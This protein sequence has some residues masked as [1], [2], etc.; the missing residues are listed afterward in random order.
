MNRIKFCLRKITAFICLIM[1]AVILPLAVSANS[2][3]PV[4]IIHGRDAVLTFNYPSRATSNKSVYM[5]YDSENG[6]MSIYPRSDFT[7]TDTDA[8]M[9]D[10]HLGYNTPVDGAEYIAVGVSYTAGKT[11]SASVST[12]DAVIS[13]VD[14]A[15]TSEIQNIVF[16]AS[17]AADGSVYDRI[18]FK[19]GYAADEIITTDVTFAVKYIA[20][21]ET[22][23]AAEAYVYTKPTEEAPV[24]V[25]GNHIKSVSF[26]VLTAGH[27]LSAAERSYYMAPTI[28]QYDPDIIGLQEANSTWY[29][30]MS[31][32][33]GDNYGSIVK[34]RTSSDSES[35]PIFWKKDKFELLDS[36][37]FWLSE[38]PDTESTGWGA[39]YHRIVC[40]V[41]LKVRTTGYE[42]YYFNTHWD[43]TETPQIESA[44]LFYNKITNECEGLPVILSA[45]FNMC[46]N[47]EGYAMLDSFL[48]ES[49]RDRDL[50]NTYNAKSDNVNAGSL[51][52]FVFYTGDSIAS[53]NYTVIKDKI[54]TKDYTYHLSDHYGVFNDLYLLGIPNEY[55]VTYTNKV[56]GVDP[57]PQTIIENVDFELAAGTPV[58]GK[59]FLGWSADGGTT[60]LNGTFSVYGDT[61]LTA[62][63]ED[64]DTY[65]VTYMYGDTVYK[66]ET[67]NAG[68]AYT[69]ITDVSDFTPD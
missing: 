8:T 23:E 39:T 9:F 55:T 6:I 40:W 68:E 60:L 28:L 59:R 42:F 38:T 2:S 34:W 20:F 16:D 10:I 17:A 47:S 30:Y 46:W 3:E 25:E 21:F 36:G 43:F 11:V 66:S 33:L 7:V 12:E 31:E 51:I 65:T 35:T 49:N 15:L 54:V 14:V 13:T 58:L 64:T 44:K 53:D 67:V 4:D 62:V 26:N 19:T 37:Y 50:Q 52:D 41:K 1:L 27:D 61:E 22:K 18:S 56:T 5:A 29:A 48:T 32:H 69:V 57:E 63:Y 24:Y 45:D